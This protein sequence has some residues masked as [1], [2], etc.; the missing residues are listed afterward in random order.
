MLLELGERGMVRN[1]TLTEQNQKQSPRAKECAH[2][3]ED[4]PPPPAARTLPGEVSLEP[5]H[6]EK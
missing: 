1:P 4:P 6:L 2:S 5:G 3:S